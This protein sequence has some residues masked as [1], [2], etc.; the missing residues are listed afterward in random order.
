[1]QQLKS[2]DVGDYE[3]SDLLGVKIIG[4]QLSINAVI[5]SVM[6]HHSSVI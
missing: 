3:A 5:P 4:R 1:V 6:I 2:V